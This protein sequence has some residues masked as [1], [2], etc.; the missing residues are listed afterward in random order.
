MPEIH[1]TE[2]EE[3]FLERVWCLREQGRNTKP[4][5]IGTHDTQVREELLSRFRDKGFILLQEGSL[6]FTPNGETCAR[7]II[8]R[9]RLTEVLLFN[10]LKLNMSTVETSACKIEHIINDEVADS[11]CAF[12][13]HPVQCP[14][15][16]A[17]PRGPCCQTQEEKLNPLLKPL[18][19]MAVGQQARVA[20]IAAKKDGMLHRL[21]S[22]GI[23]PGTLI[24]IRQ[25]SP[26]VVLRLGET[27]I[28]LEPELAKQIYCRSI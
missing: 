8:R 6:D 12:L 22:L 16:N 23:Y 19:Q 15:G 3:M 11:I 2:N 13:G 25:H 28:A 1:L 21:M 20:F 18:E 10:V 7:D 4:F 5:V 24:S 26:T 9:R 14:H 27:D 17:I